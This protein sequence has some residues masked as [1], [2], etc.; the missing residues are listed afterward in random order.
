MKK[1]G[2]KKTTS[3]LFSGHFGVVEEVFDGRALYLDIP[4]EGERRCEIEALREV[5]VLIRRA[6]ASYL[7][8]RECQTLVRA[9]E[10]VKHNPPLRLGSVGRTMAKS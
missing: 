2:V 7:V 8:Y 6:V 4:R 5:D 3:H 10:M 9:W 1:D